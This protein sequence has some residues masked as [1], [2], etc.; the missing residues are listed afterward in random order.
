MQEE[1]TTPT[2]YPRLLR[3]VRAGLID[4]MVIA[5]LFYVWFFSLAILEDA[6]PKITV[7]ALGVLLLAAEPGLVARTG[8]TIGHHL[9]GLRIRDAR[10]DRRI[11]FFRATLRALLRIFLGWFSLVVVLATRQHQTVH[12]HASRSMVVLRNPQGL[13]E[14]ERLK[15]RVLEEEGTTLPGLARRL[16]VIFAYWTLSYLAMSV[17][18]GLSV[19]ENCLNQVACSDA[20]M[21][22]IASLG[23]VWT[24]FALTSLVLGLRGRLYGC[25]SRPTELPD[26]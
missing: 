6:N 2:E 12:D 9:M 20:D 3:R 4:S 14:H 8:G 15:E 25:R 24:V 7:A 17:V 1:D 13:P 5:G 19:S 21:T 26:A 16:L 10:A 22:I 11:G 18:T 23:L